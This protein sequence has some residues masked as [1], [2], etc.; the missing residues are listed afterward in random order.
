MA[1]NLNAEVISIGT[2][3]LLGEI[4]DTN[5]VYIARA[6]RQLGI[7]LFF[8]T[9]VGDNEQRI[10][11]AIRIAMS[12]ADIVITCGGLGPTVDDK[13]R[14]GVALATNRELTFR[15]DLLD[16]IAERFARF[17][18]KMSENNRRQAFLPQ[19]AIPVHNP[20]GTAPAFIVEHNDKL[21]IS[22]P[23]VPREMK[24]LLNEAIVPFLQKRYKLGIIL[25]KILRVAGIGESAL[26]DLLG[27]ELLQQ[28]N[29]TVGLAAHHGQIDIRIT[30]KAD[31]KEQAEAMIAEIEA[32]IRNRAAKYIFGTDDEQLERVLSVL[33][34]EQ[35]INLAIAEV[36]TG[37]PVIAQKLQSANANA[38]I[39]YHTYLDSPDKLK[40]QFEIPQNMTTITEIADWLAGYIRAQ[41]SAQAAIVVIGQPDDREMADD[42]QSTI[43]TVHTPF[44]QRTRTYGFGGKNE[45][46]AKWVTNWSLAMLWRM[47]KDNHHG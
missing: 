43:V 38:H 28:S 32:Q 10:S 5:S 22:L 18:V 16:E 37:A 8:T 46:A 41:S 24:Y 13:T 6:L 11:D 39:A 27:D 30:A 17:K 42:A 20:V 12:R 7:N 3:I 4:T 23:G 21:V 14:Q 40:S 26:D 36:G 25:A 15:Q 44:G 34:H 33:L 9:S 31:T 47:L 2:E 19:D 29:P 35:N 45:I 1:E